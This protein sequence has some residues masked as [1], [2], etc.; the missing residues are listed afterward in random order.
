MTFK[1]GGR[2]AKIVALSK[3]L[4]NKLLINMQKI[5]LLYVSR[6][7]IIINMAVKKRLSDALKLDFP[8]KLQMSINARTLLRLLL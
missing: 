6:I 1:N 2:A 8:Q 3:I 7:T 4:S 5:T